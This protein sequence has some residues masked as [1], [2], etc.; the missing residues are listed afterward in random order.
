MR[1]VIIGADAVEAIVA[2]GLLG[3]EEAEVLYIAFD[4]KNFCTLNQEHK[5]SVWSMKRVQNCGISKHL[6]DIMARVIHSWSSNV[7]H[8]VCQGGLLLFS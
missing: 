6:K 7:A 8:K 1:R 4:V 2:V 5:F 3:A